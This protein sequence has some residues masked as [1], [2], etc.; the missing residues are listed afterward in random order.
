MP[1]Q[2]RTRSFPRGLP[3]LPASCLGSV[4]PGRTRDGQLNHWLALV[5]LKQCEAWA[6]ASRSSPAHAAGTLCPP[7]PPGVPPSP[8]GPAV[9]AVPRSQPPR[10]GIPSAHARYPREKQPHPQPA[11]GTA[12]SPKGSATYG[13]G[14]VLERPPAAGPPPVGVRGRAGTCAWRRSPR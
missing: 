7:A 13:A 1:G 8:D 4:K 9:S 5:V 10:L 12:S 3:A 11:N 14:R 6:G 2:S